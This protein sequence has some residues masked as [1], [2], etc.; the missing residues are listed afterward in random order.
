MNHRFI[1]SALIAFGFFASSAFAENAKPDT[2]LSKLEAATIELTKGLNENQAK[3]FAAINN[4]FGVIRSVEDVQQSISLAVES[5]SNAN[6]DMKDSM[7]N[8]FET[9]KETIRPVLKK[10][11]GKLD[12]MVILQSIAP[13]SQ[14]RAYLKKFDE[15][16]IFRNQKLKPVPISK[17]EDCQ[18]LQASMDETQKN[19]VSL[20]T[21]SLG[22]DSDLKVKE[23]GK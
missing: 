3:Q 10:A 13:T 17:A 12:Q 8:R 16:I 19:L 15:A 23:T 5:C 9:W 2:P 21:E 7:S 14:V 1:L 4:S 11:R 18:K 20:I 22:L 6:P